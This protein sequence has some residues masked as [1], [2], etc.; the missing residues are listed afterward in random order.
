MFTFYPPD[1]GFKKEDVRRGH[2]W[3]YA[4]FE[5]PKCKKLQPVSATGSVGGPCVRCGYSP[6]RDV[7]EAS[8]D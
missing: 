7:Q 3:L 1:E 4:D 5:C 2:H 6:S 8:H